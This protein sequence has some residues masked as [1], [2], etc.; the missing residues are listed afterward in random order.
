MNMLN[1][2]NIRLHNRSQNN[3]FEE[4]VC[5]L[6]R[7]DIPEHKEQFYR[8]GTPDGGVEC[9][10]ELKDHTEVGWQAKYVFTVEEL[11]PQVDDSIRTAITNHPELITYIVAIPFNLPDP[12]YKRNGKPVKSAKSKWED[13]VSKWKSDFNAEGRFIDIILWD[14]SYLIDL[15]SAPQNEGLRYY[16]FNGLEFTQAWFKEK[17]DSTIQDLGPRYTPELNIELDIADTFDLL[18]RNERPIKS[19]QKYYFEIKNA[20]NE[21]QRATKAQ[22]KSDNFSSDIDLLFS[23]AG[24]FLD[25]LKMYDYSEMKALKI[26]E[27][28]KCISQLENVHSDLWI[29]YE[30]EYSE[31][32]YRKSS[33]YQALNGL[34]DAL[35]HGRELFTEQSRMLNYPFMLLQGEPGVGKSHLIADICTKLIHRGY[36]CAMLLGDHFFAVSDPREQIKQFFQ[37]DGTFNSFLQLLN[38]IGQANGQR[39]LLAIDA[40]NEGT[41]NTLWPR[42]L[43]GLEAEISRYP[44]IALVVSI[45]D[46]YFQDII[47]PKSQETMIRVEHR[48]FEDVYDF[49]CDKFFEH[50]GIDFG[51]P[52]F[53]HEFTNPLF[54][55]LFCE[56]CKDVGYPHTLPS[57]PGVFKH[58]I[59][60]INKKLH[61]PFRY[62]PSLNLVNAALETLAELLLQNN[63]HS[64]SYAEY[65]QSL[66]TLVTSTLGQ[67][68]TDE[69]FNYLDA[70]IN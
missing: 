67:R 52:V 15:L 46:D 70:L 44:W 36:P 33:I 6:A 35:N 49:V 8:L 26:E 31:R 29:K 62:D 61:K 4:V 21:M 64:I 41:G 7:H 55:K 59:Q 16:W 25:L 38:S 23:T 9:Y 43:A 37:F 5:Q 56:S 47:P 54:L 11:I 18:L 68:S 63:T 40:L 30:K 19:I 66:E 13:K 28:V 22:Q 14:E 32:E 57:L 24:Q 1:W 65:H 53:N 10:W 20:Y 45:R 42:F 2:Q 60:H 50:Y 27:A 58:F 12:H 39:F 48:G 34:S 51:L 3:A 17:L 69:Y